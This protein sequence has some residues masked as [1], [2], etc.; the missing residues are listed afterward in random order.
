MAVLALERCRLLEL[1][2]ISTAR[3]RLA[4]LQGIFDLQALISSD[5]SLQP[6][7]SASLVAAAETGIMAFSFNRGPLVAFRVDQA[8]R[9]AIS[10]ELAGI[11][12]SIKDEGKPCAL[13]HSYQKSSSS[14]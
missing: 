6:R 10:I 14:V 5:S 1:A 4:R 7:Y 12:S 11:T 3:S 8:Q 2:A 13:D 9:T